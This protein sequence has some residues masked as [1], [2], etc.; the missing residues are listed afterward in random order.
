[1]VSAQLTYPHVPFLAD[2]VERNLDLC[3]G[4]QTTPHYAD[5]DDAHKTFMFS[6]GLRM[7]PEV[8]ACMQEVYGVSKWDWILF[9]TKL[10]AIHALPA[11]V[12]DTAL[13]GMVALDT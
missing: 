6:R 3:P 13:E 4:K 11:V 10:Q 5:E 12:I 9:R 1:M 2:L 8:W 7:A